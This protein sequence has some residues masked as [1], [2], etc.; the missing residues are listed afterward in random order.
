MGPGATG[1]LIDLWITVAQGNPEGILTGWDEED[2]AYSGNWDGDPKEFISA[3]IKC[4]FLTIN[5]NECYEI[6]DWC[7]HQGYACKA[8]ERSE[9]A[10]KA[11]TA[12]WRE[13]RK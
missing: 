5:E 10:K 13:K 12:R 2:I 1:N 4:N 11:A 8:R 3:L 9:Q 6:H 7:D